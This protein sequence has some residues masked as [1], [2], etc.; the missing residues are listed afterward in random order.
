MDGRDVIW[1]GHRMEVDTILEIERDKVHALG[2][3]L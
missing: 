2:G 3:Y 1:G